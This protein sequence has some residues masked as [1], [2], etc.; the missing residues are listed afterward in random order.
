MRKPRT[1]RCL[2]IRRARFRQRDILKAAGAATIERPFARSAPRLGAGGAGVRGDKSFSTCAK[3]S[4]AALG[5]VT[6]VTPDSFARGVVFLRR[7][8]PT[9]APQR[10]R[11]FE[12]SGLASAKLSSVGTSFQQSFRLALASLSVA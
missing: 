3:R 8:H 6:H 12:L 4:S 9:A 5:R 1:L 2:T 10:G 7:A 11:V